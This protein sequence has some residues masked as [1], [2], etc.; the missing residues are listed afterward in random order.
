MET[1]IKVKCSIWS[2]SL[3][4]HN[5]GQTVIYNTT[6]GYRNQLQCVNVVKKERGYLLAAFL[7]SR[8]G[9][10][11]HFSFLSI[12]LSFVVFFPTLPFLFILFLPCHF[13]LIH[14][15]LFLCLLSLRPIRY[16]KLWTADVWSVCTPNGMQLCTLV[17]FPYCISFTAHCVAITRRLLM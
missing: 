16:V 5:R 13:P 9:I 17:C 2:P 8:A 4:W 3:T 14:L 11:I 15:R 1:R 10:S 7:M 6:H 12:F